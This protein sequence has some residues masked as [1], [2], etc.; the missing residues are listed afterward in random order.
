M[1]KRLTFKIDSMFEENKDRFGEKQPLNKLKL[2]NYEH[3]R[4]LE[5]AMQE[6]LE[7][8]KGSIIENSQG[9]P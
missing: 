8:R 2:G 4:E 3:L 1:A 6:E 7:D 5:Y 9:K